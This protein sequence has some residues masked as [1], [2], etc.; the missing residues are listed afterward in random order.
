MLIIL[1][2]GSFGYLKEDSCLTYWPDGMFSCSCDIY[3]NSDYY[4]KFIL[5]YTCTVWE[6]EMV[7][8]G[9]C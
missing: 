6:R 9:E 7:F 8:I 2:S 3:S 5:L 4:E 1:S